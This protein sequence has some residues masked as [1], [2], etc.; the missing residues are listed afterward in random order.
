MSDRTEDQ[1]VADGN[2]SKNNHLIFLPCFFEYKL[3]VASE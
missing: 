3:E 1:Q 2:N